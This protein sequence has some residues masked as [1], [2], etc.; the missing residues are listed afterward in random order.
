VHEKKGVVKCDAVS[1]TCQ[2]KKDDT[3]VSRRKE[4][5]SVVYERKSPEGQ[6]R[7]GRGRVLRNGERRSSQ[8]GQQSA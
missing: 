1:N 2:F 8:K 4:H 6:N 7:A 3:V 5:A